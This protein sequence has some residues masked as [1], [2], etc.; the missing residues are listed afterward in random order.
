MHELGIMTDV[1]DTAIRV[2]EDNGGRQVTKITLKIGLMSG[3]KAEYVQS[4]FAVIS[5]DTIAQKAEIAIENDPA[6][7]V[8]RSCGGKTVYEALGPDYI[9]SACGSQALRLV[10]GHGFP[11]VNAGIK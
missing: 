6:V 8:C 4:F 1:L 5:K 10:S 3:V 11:I 9:C 2:A 7:F